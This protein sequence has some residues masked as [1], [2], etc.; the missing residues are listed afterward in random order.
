MLKNSTILVTGGAGAIGCNLVNELAGGNQIIVLDNLA[1]GHITNIPHLENVDFISASILDDDALCQV[2]SKYSIDY[3]FHLAANFAN[4]NSVLFPRRDLQVNSLGTL[5]LLQYS[6]KAGIKCFLYTSSSCVYGKNCW[7]RDEKTKEYDPDTPYA[8]SKL[9]GEMYVNFFNRHWKVPTV[10][11]RIFNSYGP[12]EYPGPFRNA[13]TNFFWAA[14]ND[15]PLL[16]TGT[17]SETRDFTFVGDT[18]HGLLLAATTESAY[19]QVFNIGTGKETRIIDV[20]RKII[21]LTGSK[22]ALLFGDKR[23]WDNIPRRR[24]NIYKAKNALGF[25]PATDLDAGLRM[26]LAWFERQRKS[27]CVVE[28]GS[29]VTN[30]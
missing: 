15:N 24:A 30:R 18:V 12:G 11:T 19:G 2:F 5:K 21:S 9:S 3:V 22:S 25:E 26:T 17:G 13:I 7:L 16:I 10:I 20:A 29:S 8:I 14:M 23:S 28:P 27:G 6:Q 1:S 4:Q